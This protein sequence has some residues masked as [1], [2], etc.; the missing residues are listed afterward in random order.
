MDLV[1]QLPDVTIDVFGLRNSVEDADDISRCDT[2]VFG[3]TGLTRAHPSLRNNG[4]RLLNLKLVLKIMMCPN[5]VLSL[6]FRR[7]GQSGLE[8]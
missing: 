2:A 1:L 5:P 8:W 4:L 6:A 7:S 3:L